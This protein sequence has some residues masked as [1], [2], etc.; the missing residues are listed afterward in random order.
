MP[1]GNYCRREVL[2][3]HAVK[4]RLHL[5]AQARPCQRGLDQLQSQ[6]RPLPSQGVLS[7]IYAVNTKKKCAKVRKTP[8]KHPL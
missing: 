7:G 6:L 3:L 1:D 8:P 4:L 5:G 2:H